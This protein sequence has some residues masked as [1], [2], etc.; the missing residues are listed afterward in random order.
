[1]KDARLAELQDLLNAQQR[2]FNESCV[3]RTLPVLL[4]RPGRHAGQLVGRSP[5]M[6]AVHVKAPADWLGRLVDLP[7]VSAGGNSLGAGEG[8]AA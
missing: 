2:R 4:D 6:Q 3:G 8:M 1:M 5:Y 7:I